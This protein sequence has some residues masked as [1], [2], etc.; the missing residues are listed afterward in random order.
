[1]KREQGDNLISFF[2]SSKLIIVKDEKEI[3]NW[4]NNTTSSS[5]SNTQLSNNN[6]LKTLVNAS[7]LSVITNATADTSDAKSV[8]K[9]E[10]AEF[11]ND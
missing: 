7:P 1:M 4:S 10:A 11:D 3:T 8:A 2:F 6:R 9:S 5:D